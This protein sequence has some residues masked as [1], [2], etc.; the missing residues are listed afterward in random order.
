MNKINLIR[1]KLTNIP[2]LHKQWKYRKTDLGELNFAVNSSFADG[3]RYKKWL[4]GR[5]LVSPV[6]CKVLENII[7]HIKTNTFLNMRSLTK[8]SLAFYKLCNE[9][10]FEEL[11][12]E[13]NLHAKIETRKRAFSS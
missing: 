1:I 10:L 2:H 8:R 6:V 9:T 12:D 3:F 5:S 7:Y 4:P 13:I 11:A